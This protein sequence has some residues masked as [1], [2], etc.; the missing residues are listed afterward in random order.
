MSYKSE[1]EDHYKRVRE[2]MHMG[3]KSSIV[4]KKLI[5]AALPPGGIAGGTGLVPPLQVM[6]VPPEVI[7]APPPKEH[8]NE[9]RER[10]QTAGETARARV[11]RDN[12]GMP[13]MVPL[14]NFDEKG[15]SAAW[16]RV[17]KA[18]AKNYDLEEADIFGPRRARNV[19]QARFECMY[20]MRVD[21][22]MSYL[23]IAAKM[24]RDHSTVIHGV[25]TILHRL[26]DEQKRR[27]HSAKV[28]AHGMVPKLDAHPQLAA[29]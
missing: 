7:D 29:A 22:R 20:R 2:R 24:R 8:K 28:P 19:V 14:A 15:Q 3:V 9:A 11:E 13:K 23:N 18:V 5:A 16:K 21:L 1:L 10:A 4:P 6:E 17:V 26:L 25:N 27:M 12:E